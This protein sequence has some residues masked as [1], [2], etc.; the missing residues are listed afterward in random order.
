MQPYDA[1]Y[2]TEVADMQSDLFFHTNRKLPGVDTK[3]FIEKFMCSEIRAKLDVGNPFFL[4][5]PY[6]EIRL[7]FIQN[8]CDGTYKKGESWDELISAWVGFA[9]SYYQWTYNVPSCDIIKQLPLD[10]MERCYPALH[11]CGWKNAVG[12]LYDIRG[13]Q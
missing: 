11:Q 10:T 4:N 12:K 3:W 7:R 2:V 13:T 8:E 9:Y 6:P 1:G 5:S